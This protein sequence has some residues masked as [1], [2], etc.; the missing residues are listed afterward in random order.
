MGTANML[1]WQNCKFGKQSRKDKA[2]KTMAIFKREDT[3]WVRFTTPGG[4]R[5]RRS[6]KTSDK[7][8]A[9]EFEDRLK[10]EYWRVQT[11]GDKPRRT[12]KEA[13]VRW[14]KDT[15]YKVDHDKDKS[16]L[17][18]LDQFLGNLYLDEIDR[19]LVDRI[20]AAKRDEAGSSASTANRHL[21]LI[22]SILRAARDE[23][24]W[25]D[26]I[27]MIRLYTEPKRRIRWITPTEARALL[28]EL[29]THLAD[30]AEFSL[31]TGLRQSNVSYLRW[32]Q[33][34]LERQLAWIEAPDIKNRKALSVQLNQTAIA[35]L[36][37][38]QP[39]DD[40][41]VFTYQGNPVARTST[42]AWY[43]ALKRA[44]ISNFRWHDLRHTWASW[45]VQHGTSLQELMELG[46]WSSYEMVLRYAHLASDHLQEAAS[47]IDGTNLAQS[48]IAKSQT[49][50]IDSVSS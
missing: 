47:R 37:R 2:L 13:A 40:T 24:E 32:D 27:P 33:L 46:G 30:M 8:Q 31:A 1:D 6:T 17:R 41:Y 50:I 11:L 14:S 5:I 10:A 44:G 43:A 49:C 9:Q 45:H 4:K 26:R 12:W 36:E 15:A 23:W 7:K 28:S 42:K 19:E 25:V 20:G 39:T 48:N 35:V 29:P 34:S 3:W 22:R 18:W 16:K 21:A 38:R